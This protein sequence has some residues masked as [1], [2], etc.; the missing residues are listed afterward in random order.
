MNTDVY[1]QQEKE[2]SAGTALEQDLVCDIVI[3]GGGMAGLMCAQQLHKAG[4][5]AVILEKDFCGAGASGKTSGFITPDSE[6]ELSSLVENYGPTEAKRIWEFVV[7][8]VDAI[9]S[10]IEQYKIDCDYEVQDS[11]FVGTNKRGFEHTQE[12]HAARQQLSYESTLYTQERLSEVLGAQGY[13]GG[14]RYPDTFGMNSYLYCQALRDVLVGEGVVIYEHT[15]VTSLGKGSLVANGKKIMA[16]HIV[17]AADH[18]ALQLGLL[19]YQLYHIQT[20]LG[21]TKP[22]SDDAIK[23]IFPQDRMMV[24]DTDLVYEYYRLTGDNRMLIGGADLRYTYEMNERPEA[25]RPIA[26]KMLKYMEQRF[27]G[28]EF[29]LESIW[30]GMLGVTKDLLPIMGQDKDDASVTYIAA[31]SGLPWAAALGKYVADKVKDGRSDFDSVFTPYRTFV[32]S[33]LIEKIAH[34]Q[35]TYALAHGYAKYQ[36]RIFALIAD[37]AKELYKML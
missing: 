11:L 14:V 34:K 3:V 26:R 22:L 31:A 1:W 17:V 35:I 24:W 13:F 28:I 20:F 27:P 12:E 16:K 5:A 15:A 29:P 10:N 32:A 33:R 18:F 23:Q 25:P 21:I 9:R 37:M 7:S 4:I 36:S 6:I 19:D 8:G 30:P 2:P